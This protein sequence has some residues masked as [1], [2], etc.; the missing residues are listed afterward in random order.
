ML[1]DPEIRAAYVLAT[2]QAAL[3]GGAGFRAIATTEPFETAR[4]IPDGSMMTIVCGSQDPL[5]NP[6][7]SLPSWQA[8]WPGCAVVLVPDG[9]RLVHFQKPE[10]IAGLLRA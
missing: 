3:Q 2:Q 6:A 8:A 4:P 7:D 5:Y 9:G 1:S 10:L